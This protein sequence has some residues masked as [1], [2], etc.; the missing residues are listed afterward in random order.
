M[1][2]KDIQKKLALKT[3]RSAR[4]GVEALIEADDPALY[5]AALSG[6]SWGKHRYR[7][8]FVGGVFAPDN[9]TELVHA[10]LPRALPRS[11]AARQLA[12]QVPRLVLNNSSTN[13]IPLLSHFTGLTS[14]Q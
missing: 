5:E 1:D 13:L 4:A 14:H 11:P 6:V 7:E 12:A 9:A 3:L 8:G 10:L 2:W